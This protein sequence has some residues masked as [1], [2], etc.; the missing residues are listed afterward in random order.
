MSAVLDY[1]GTGEYY[2]ISL[3]RGGFWEEVEYIGYESTT[4][5]PEERLASDVAYRVSLRFCTNTSILREACPYPVHIPDSGVTCRTQ[6]PLRYIKR[7][8]YF[9]QPSRHP[10]HHRR[11]QLHRE[12]ESRRAIPT[13]VCKPYRQ[14]THELEKPAALMSR[15]G[16][17]YAMLC[18][19]TLA[20]WYMRSKVQDKMHYRWDSKELRQNIEYKHVCDT[21]LPKI[22]TNMGKST[23]ESRPEWVNRTIINAERDASA[24]CKALPHIVRAESLPVECEL[25]AFV[26]LPE[27]VSGGLPRELEAILVYVLDA[28]PRGSGGRKKWGLVASLIYLSQA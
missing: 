6:P 5:T 3:N 8:P 16:F 14:E 25:A 11:P 15:H 20:V 2:T 19:Q 22:S 4:R 23:L 13:L 10:F 9:P 1:R 26:W 17:I 21:L 7:F 27:I 28:P 24:G 18:E 12:L